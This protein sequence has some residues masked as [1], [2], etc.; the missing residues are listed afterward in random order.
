MCDLKFIAEKQNVDSYQSGFNY[1]LLLNDDYCL[2]F[3]F[4]LNDL[5][6]KNDDNDPNRLHQ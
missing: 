4:S 5:L 2:K 3:L 6:N 1:D